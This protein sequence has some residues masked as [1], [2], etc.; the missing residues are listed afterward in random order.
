MP[1]PTGENGPETNPDAP[2]NETSRADTPWHDAGIILL[3]PHE[4]QARRAVIYTRR[5]S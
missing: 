5:L 1:E 2:T 4:A 3:A